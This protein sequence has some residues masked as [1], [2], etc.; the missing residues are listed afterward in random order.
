MMTKKIAFVLC[1]AA[2]LV[3]CHRGENR[4]GEGSSGNS[5]YSGSSGSQGGTSQ[6]V[7]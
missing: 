3:G 1:L 4:S 2:L 6:G 7:Y 5:S